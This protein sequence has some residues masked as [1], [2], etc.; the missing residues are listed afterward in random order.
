MT[1]CKFYQQ[2]R[3]KF[4]S[5]CMNQHI[6]STTSFGKSNFSFNS[7]T[8]PFKTSNFQKANPVES[9]RTYKES[10]IVSDLENF[11]QWRFTSYG[12]DGKRPCLIS[13]TDVSY[14]ELRLEYYRSVLTN[15]QT[16]YNFYVQNCEKKIDH[17]LANILANPKAALKSLLNSEYKPSSHSNSTLNSSFNASNPSQPTFGNTASV[18]GSSNK[19]LTTFGNTGSA[20][21]SSTS[22]QP[23][24]GN[25][26]SVFG[27]STSTQPTFGNTDN[28]W[29]YCVFGSSTSTQPTFGNTGSTFGSSTSTQPTFGNTGS[30]FGSSNPSQPTFGNA[31]SA[32]GSSTSS[33]PT[34]GNTGSAF[35]SSNKT[36]TTFGNTGSAFGSSNKTQTTFG[37]TG[38]AFGSSNTPAAPSFGSSAFSFSNAN[39]NIGLNNSHTSKSNLQNNSS[40]TTLNQAQ[41]A[42]ISFNRAFTNTGSDTDFYFGSNEAEIKS[43]ICGPDSLSSNLTADHIAVFKSLHF[44]LGKIPEIPPSID[45]C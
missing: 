19:T 13:G 35:G 8:S 12:I 27:S 40:F 3:C 17:E 26:A 16:S 39:N 7:I 5:N 31:G 37:N 23:T 1:I 2:G 43:T 33:Q 25:T 14:E 45:L 44:E 22:T 24:F 10:D 11:P 29:E 9:G 21:A 20:F 15:N 30:A 41:P 38:S 36:Q 6:D 4:G 42:A 32:F 34:F 28:I 18:F